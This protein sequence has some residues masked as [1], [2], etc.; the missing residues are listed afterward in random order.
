MTVWGNIYNVSIGDSKKTIMSSIL[1]TFC[2]NRS[3]TRSDIVVTLNSHKL[4][5]FDTI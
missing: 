2:D 3:V 5:Q 1:V 4:R